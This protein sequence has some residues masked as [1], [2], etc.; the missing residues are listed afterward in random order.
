M[1][2]DV[3]IAVG[4]VTEVGAFSGEIHRCPLPFAMPIWGLHDTGVYHSLSDEKLSHSVTRVVVFAW[5][6]CEVEDVIPAVCPWLQHFSFPL[7]WELFERRWEISMSPVRPLVM[8]SRRKHQY[9]TANTNDDCD[10][11]CALLATPLVHAPD[12]RS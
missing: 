6:T 9:C 2:L 1:H 10:L 7:D 8:F 11:L 5:N 12:P 3:E 4:A